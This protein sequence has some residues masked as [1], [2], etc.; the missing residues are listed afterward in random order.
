MKSFG[1][2]EFAGGGGSLDSSQ[3]ADFPYDLVLH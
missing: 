1:M 3:V 2:I